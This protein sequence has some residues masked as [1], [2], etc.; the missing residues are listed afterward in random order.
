MIDITNREDR[1]FAMALKQC[2]I[3]TETNCA[4]CRFYK[5]I[6][7]EDWIRLDLHDRIVL[8]EPEEYE[9]LKGE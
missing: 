2:T 5:P 6:H 3:L 4:D 8:V 7:C 9:K 1:C